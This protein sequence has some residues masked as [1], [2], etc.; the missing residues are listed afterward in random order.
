MLIYLT[1]HSPS[2]NHSLLVLLG[3]F[4]GFYFDI[5]ALHSRDTPP[6]YHLTTTS[7]SIP[8]ICLHL[9]R[10]LACHQAGLPPKHA[11]RYFLTCYSISNILRWSLKNRVNPLGPIKMIILRS[12]SISHE[13]WHTRTQGAQHRLLRYPGDPG[14]P[15]G[16]CAGTVCS[17]GGGEKEAAQLRP[18]HDVFGAL[19]LEHGCFLNI[20]S[21]YLK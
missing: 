19:A 16:D 4:L 14:N 8:D 21:G 2:S 20:P 6:I 5:F 15:G 9:V 18:G 12:P 3:F 11:D 17:V 1:I 10:S 13:P 7:R